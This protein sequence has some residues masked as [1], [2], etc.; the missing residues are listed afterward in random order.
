MAAGLAPAQMTFSLTSSR[1][2]YRSGEPVKLTWKL[3]NGANNTWF[4][5]RKSIP[6]GY[7]Q[8]SLKIEGPSGTKTFPAGGGATAASMVSMCWLG[9]GSA[10]EG[11]F[12]LSESAN[13]SGYPLPPGRYR[14]A[15]TFDHSRA[16]WLSMLKGSSGPACNQVTPL[17]RPASAQ[18]I[19]DAVLT[20]PAVEF[21]IK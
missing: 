12:D 20:A 16:R 8:I 6:A 10:I 5:Y 21:S 11:S 9:P 2:E 3:T 7:Q 4:L 18:D 14:V 1:S 19:L 13:L 17:A 15:A